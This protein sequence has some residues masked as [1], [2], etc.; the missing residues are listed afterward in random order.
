MNW[1]QG[2]GQNLRIGKKAMFYF[3]LDS[4][5]ALNLNI[6][7]SFLEFISNKDAIGSYSVLV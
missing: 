1:N 4:N 3:A 2:K 6:T 5:N 7:G